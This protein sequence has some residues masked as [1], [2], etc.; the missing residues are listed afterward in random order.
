MVLNPALIRDPRDGRLHMLFRA[1]GQ[2]AEP[3]APSQPAP[4]PIFLGYMFSADG[5]ATWSADL[6][7]PALA[8]ALET[9]AENIR[10][11]TA[12]GQTSVNYANG[13]IEDPRLFWLEGVCHMIAACRMFPPGPYWIHDDPIQCAPD[14][15]QLPDAPG[16]RAARE[17]VTVNVLFRVDLDALRTG[18]YEQAFAF[19]THLTDP[20]LG[21]NRDVLLFP[22]KLRINGRVQFVCIHRPQEPGHYPGGGDTMRPSI[23][24]CAAESLDDISTSP[25]VQACLAEPMFDWELNRIG[26]SAPLLELGGGEWLLAYHGK[27]DAVTGYTQSFM[28]LREQPTGLP[29]VVHR[30][31]E[32]LFVPEE[33]WEQ[34]DR[35]ETPCVFTTGLE[36][37]G[38][39]LIVAYG[40]ADQ[41]VGIARFD[42]KE[43]LRRVRLYDAEGKTIATPVKSS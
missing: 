9:Q 31:P 6:S 24:I 3:A 15:A 13:C 40:A 39:E 29:V 34:P 43:L 18:R 37:A 11:K 28:I 33:D 12:T 42:R 16:G 20:E 32:R 26:A 25:T 10:I 21:E 14:W 4:Y 8:P 19:V 7:R 2:W 27:R 35:F 30:C 22:R 1:T 38:D 41:R 23:W 5:G 36:E 17:N